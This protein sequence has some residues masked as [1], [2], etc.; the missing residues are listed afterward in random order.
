[1]LF[2]LST[3]FGTG[4]LRPG[5]PRCPRPMQI[6]MVAVSA[7]LFC[8]AFMNE[9]IKYL[10]MERHTQTNSDDYDSD[11]SNEFRPLLSSNYNRVRQERLRRH[12]YHNSI[13][14]RYMEH[15]DRIFLSSIYFLQT[16]LTFATMLAVMTF[17]FWLFLAAILGT[18]VGTQVFQQKKFKPK[19]SRASLSGTNELQTRGSGQSGYGSIGS[20]SE[21][22][23]MPTN[24]SLVDSTSGL[25]DNQIV[26]VEVHQH[27]GSY[28]IGRDSNQIQTCHLMPNS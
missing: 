11:S 13:A 4:T 25:Q 6:G 21:D 26:A 22:D 12:R 5:S 20:D 3:V 19:I 10:R 17:S 18:G 2:F 15:A 24:S 9:G 28:S 23:S 16:V 27:N 8:L 14:L 1:M 7:G